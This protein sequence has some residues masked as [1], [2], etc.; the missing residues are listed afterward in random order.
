MLSRFNAEI[1]C[2]MASGLFE[3]SNLR[4]LDEHLIRVGVNSKVRSFF[5]LCFFDTCI[6]GVFFPRMSSISRTLTKRDSNLC[7]TA[8]KKQVVSF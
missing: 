1:A 5:S 4:G 2:R 3:E 6:V 7:T 8:G